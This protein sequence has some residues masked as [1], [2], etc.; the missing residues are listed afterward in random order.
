[1]L[2]TDICH[3]DAES[4][5]IVYKLT[6]YPDVHYGECDIYVCNVNAVN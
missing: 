3:V 4:M 2:V 6:V 1:M 5:L